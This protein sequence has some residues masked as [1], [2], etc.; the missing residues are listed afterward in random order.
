MGVET[1][2][3]ERVPLAARREAVALEGV[4]TAAHV[5]GWRGGWVVVEVNARWVAGGGTVAQ[6]TRN[7]VGWAAA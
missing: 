1:G 5:P 2:E 4:A 3:V 6:V 7:L